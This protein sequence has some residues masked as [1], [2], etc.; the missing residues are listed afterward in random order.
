MYILLS[1]CSVQMLFTFSAVAKFA[2]AR[3]RFDFMTTWL[4]LF[5]TLLPYLPFA[6]VQTEPCQ[7]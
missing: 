4:L 1:I 6:T 3:P 5:T 7:L 2:Q